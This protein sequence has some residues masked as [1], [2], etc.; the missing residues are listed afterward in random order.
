MNVPSTINSMSSR[1]SEYISIVGLGYVGLP[2]A[3]LACEKG[4]NVFGIDSSETRVKSI[5]EGDFQNDDVDK[6]KLKIF[7][8]QGQ[9][10]VKTNFDSIEKSKVVV[11]CVPT[12]LFENKPDLTAVESVLD[13]IAN[14]LQPGTLVSLESTS[15]QGTTRNLVEH[16]LKSR[17]KIGVDFYTAFSPERI[18]PAN[19]VWKI[20]QTPKVVSSTTQEG[21]RLAK[22]FYGRLFENLVIASTPEVAELA[23]LLENSFRLVN[24]VLINQLA[25]YC[26]RVG[27]PVKEVIE[28]ASSKPFGFMPFK[29][30]LGVGGHCIPVD[31]VYLNWGARDEGLEI[32]L[33]SESLKYNRESA[34]F[35]YERILD[36]ARLNNFTKLKIGLVG[37]SYK[38]G[39]ADVRESASVDFFRLANEQGIEILWHDPLVHDFEGDLSTK[40]EELCIESNIVVLTNPSIVLPL[41]EFGSDKIVL[42]C[43]YTLNEAKNI[44]WL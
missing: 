7:L 2:L 30:S 25:R 39:V 1:E 28:I 3:L 6:S 22:S 38:S 41:A 4:F 44:I 42:D 26:A 31:P 36:I 15:Y 23:K 40:L 18:D 32:S 19:K 34:T 20:D 43:T 16:G 12:P 35:L 27:V 37:L 17:M 14:L 29:P 21:L 10:Q 13:Q 5:M 9:F 33:I 11:I 24:I 8:Q